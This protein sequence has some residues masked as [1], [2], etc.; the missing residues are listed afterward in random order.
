MQLL[1]Q[2]WSHCELAVSTRWNVCTD[3]VLFVCID[4]NAVNAGRTRACDLDGRYQ[5]THYQ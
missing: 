4:F 2:P 1:N 5:S 3:S